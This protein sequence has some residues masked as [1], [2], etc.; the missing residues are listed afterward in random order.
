[1]VIIK[2][3]LISFCAFTLTSCS[4]KRLT[5]ENEN[6]KFANIVVTNSG[7]DED[8]SF[9]KKFNLNNKQAALFFEKNFVITTKVMHDKYDYLPCF[10]EGTSLINK[11]PCK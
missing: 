11:S 3:I 4:E 2:S 10:V 6:L 1:M 8:N 5:I 9:C 7:G